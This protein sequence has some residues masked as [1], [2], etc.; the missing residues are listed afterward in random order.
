MR[1]AGTALALCASA[2]LAQNSTRI[3][4]EASTDNLNWS[5]SIGGTSPLTCYFRVTITKTGPSPVAGF[6]SMIYQPVI[7]ASRAGPN[8]TVLPFSNIQTGVPDG[9]GLPALLGRLNPFAANPMSSGTSGV[10][11]AFV[12]GNSV[13]FAGSRCTTP[14][15]NVAWGIPSEQRAP[16]LAGTNFNASSSVGVFKFAATFNDPGL[17][18]VDVPYSSINSPRDPVCYWYTSPTGTGNPVRTLVDPADIRAAQVFLGGNPCAL[19][20]TF[21]TRDPRSMSTLAGRRAA[22][23]ADYLD[24]SGFA[25]L[26]WHHDGVPVSDSARVQGATGTQLVLDASSLADAGAYTLQ[27]NGSAGLRIS[28]PA[29]L[30]IACPGDLDDGSGAGTPDAAVDVNDLL[31][32]LSRY[33]IG[34]ITAD[35]D[36]GSGLGLGDRAVT[37]D[38]LLY[39]L[40]RYERGC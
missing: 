8:F 35:V 22:F 3:S 21:I 29:T 40:E 16:I 26:R 31:Y 34:S 23:R 39:F 25:Q 37:I 9:L 30:T 17:V 18:W 12:E 10:L 38:D 24:C 13:R 28:L 19:G 32:F 1:T 4:V 6:G 11:T 14:T 15:T 7:D 2:A 5:S 33:E 20:G 36:D 27:V